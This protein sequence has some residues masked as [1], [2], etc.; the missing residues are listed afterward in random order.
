VA[1]WADRSSGVPSKYIV[2]TASNRDPS[3][4]NGQ[5]NREQF[6]I[7]FP[8]VA[9]GSDPSVKAGTLLRTLRFEGTILLPVSSTLQERKDLYAFIKNF[10]ATAAVQSM[11]QDLEHVY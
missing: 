1:T 8:V 10:L 4:G 7:S 11:V 3:N 2:L 5:V 9:D 6:S